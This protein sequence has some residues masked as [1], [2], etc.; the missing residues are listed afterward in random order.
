[1]KSVLITGC[2]DGGIGSAL[3]IT[4]AQRGLLV[5]AATRNVSKMSKLEN[6]TNVH[7]LALD[8]TEHTQVRNAVEIV[9]KATGGT[10][11]YLV[12]NAAQVRF[13][14][15]LDEP[16]GFQEARKQFDINLW[17]QMDMV[18]AFAPLLIEAKGTLVYN[19]SAAAHG[20]APWL[21]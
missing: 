8:I 17:A 9:K 6:L 16:E 11:D 1:M 13:M 5:F 14:P 3:A 2:S 18:Q 4:F 15:I 21:L 20:T 12:N 19:S 7:L 10:L